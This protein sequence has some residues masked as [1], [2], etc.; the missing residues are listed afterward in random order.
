MFYPRYKPSDCAVALLSLCAVTHGHGGC[1]QVLTSALGQDSS[2]RFV[3]LLR[4]GDESGDFS[5]FVTLLR[6][7][8]PTAIGQEFRALEVRAHAPVAAIS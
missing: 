6:R 2:S 4:S 7:M 1:E 3:E 5:D 8:S